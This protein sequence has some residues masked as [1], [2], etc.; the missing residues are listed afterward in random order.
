MINPLIMKYGIGNLLVVLY[1]F[2][3]SPIH[4]EHTMVHE[5]PQDP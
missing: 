2:Q 3:D 5:Q 1:S 4:S